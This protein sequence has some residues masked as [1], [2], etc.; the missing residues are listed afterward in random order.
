MILYTLPLES[1]HI[2][3][4]ESYSRQ[5]NIPTLAATSSG[6]YA[7]FTLRL[8]SFLPVVDTHPDDASTADL[9]LLNPWPELSTFASRMAEDIEH[10]DDHEHG[11]LPLVVILLHFL[12][13]WRL[14]HGGDAPKTYSEKIAFRALIAQE[15]RTDNSEGGEENFDEAVSSVMKHIIHPS[16]PESLRHIFQHENYSKVS[17]SLAW[18]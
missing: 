7:Y 14:I 9:R 2:A 6:F 11:H 3:F 17:F 13:K 18:P 12:E 1:K 4:L 8:H 15:S 5:H 16:L 10:Q